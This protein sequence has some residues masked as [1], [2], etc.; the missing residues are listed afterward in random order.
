MK[1]LGFTLIEVIAVIVVLALILLITVPNI[2]STT[3]R[4]KEKQWKTIEQSI[5]DAA[6]QFVTMNRDNPEWGDFIDLKIYDS[7]HPDN[8]YIDIPLKLL[9]EEGVL[10][11]PIIDPRTGEEIDY[12]G[13]VRVEIVGEGK[14]LVY[15]YPGGDKIAEK[16]I[17][18]KTI[19]SVVT[20]GGSCSV[21]LYTTIPNLEDMEFYVSTPDWRGNCNFSVDFH[22]E[23]E[24]DPESRLLGNIASLVGQNTYT[25]TTQSNLE[26]WV[27]I[28][29]IGNGESSI[30]N[31]KLE[32]SDGFK[33]YVAEAVTEGYIYPLVLYVEHNEYNY[34]F[35]EGLLDYQFISNGASSGVGKNPLFNMS[36]KTTSK[37]KLKAISYNTYFGM[38]DYTL[39][40]DMMIYEYP[41]Y[42]D[43]SLEPF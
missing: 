39:S 43:I 7:E 36:L 37:A 17:Y 35:W 5:L 13:T 21:R 24:L 18:G 23:F 11:K 6:E 16:T 8:N 30:S 40:L 4:Q 32:F 15:T 28:H 41:P 42:V 1:K 22:R 25:L 9:L 38:P 19:P 31:L 29:A 10:K 3:D 14:P 34:D 26:R 20:D 27:H 12:N 33:G 2:L